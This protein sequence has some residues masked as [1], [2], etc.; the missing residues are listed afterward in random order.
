VA[1]TLGE[2]AAAARRDRTTVLRMIKRGRLSATRDPVTGGWLI[3]P[4]ELHRLY[5]AMHSAGHSAEQ[6]NGDAGHGAG[7][8]Q[9]VLTAQLTAERARS[10]LLEGV[11][12]DLRRRLDAADR[13][14]DAEAEERRRLTALL[15]DQRVKPEA[16][17]D[18]PAPPRRGW[19]RWGRA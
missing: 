9:A 16:T 14:L 13:R 6:S 4:A 1:Y 8:A 17:S 7:D 10:A 12:D 2:A 15:A 11:V 19:W 18:L 3:E 5:P